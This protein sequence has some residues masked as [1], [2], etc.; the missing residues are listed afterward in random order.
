VVD[1]RSLPGQ[2]AVEEAIVADGFE[3]LQA[4]TTG[5]APLRPAVG[6]G[7]GSVMTN[8]AQYLGQVRGGVLDPSLGQR[9]VIEADRD[10]SVQLSGG[11]NSSRPGT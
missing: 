9:D 11:W 3:Q 7:E 4:A 5:E 6:A 8:A 2:E 10:R 1:A